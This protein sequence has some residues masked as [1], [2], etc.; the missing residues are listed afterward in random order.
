VER[1]RPS[2]SAVK[3]RPGA[4]EAPRGG[5][6]TPPSVRHQPLPPATPGG[7][8]R[9]RIP[10]GASVGAIAVVP[11]R[12]FFG[13]TFLYAGL[14][15]L[16][17]PAF[18]DPSSPSGIHAQLEGFVRMSPLAPLV[19][20]FALPFPA[21]MG[22]LI[23]I[24]EVAVGLGALTGVLFRLAAFGGVLLSL[25][26]FMTASWTVRPY[27]FGPDLPY[28][29]GWLTLAVAGTGGILE[30]EP[31]LA[32]RIPW[33]R[34]TV[35]TGGRGAGAA[36]PTRR[37]MLQAAILGAA[38]LIVAAVAIPARTLLGRQ[39]QGSAADGGNP[40]GGAS[41]GGSNGSG[42]ASGSSL[43][44]SAPG[45]SPAPGGSPAVTN[46]AAAPTLAAPSGNVIARIADFATTPS[47]DFSVPGSGDPGVLVKLP[48]GTFVAFDA[49]CTHQGCTVAYDASSGFLVC[50]C[51]GATFDTARSAAVLAGPARRPL[52]G[53]PLRVD[54]ASGTITLSS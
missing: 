42:A 28:A 31:W 36:D 41:G 29:A 1:P 35:I 18:F 4:P 22:G 17:D 46:A 27:Y 9:S 6:R 51:H 50:P 30:L 24:G 54:Q 43:P 5:Q 26:F 7:W 21:L 10:P 25:L 20:A 19:Q 14:D 13:F 32:A 23:A 16:L 33:L 34:G 49:V 2:F 53:L 40:G 39:G 38:S 3:S 37:F 8:L 47:L 52:I 44:T 45:S 11:I 12:F 48:D 15:K